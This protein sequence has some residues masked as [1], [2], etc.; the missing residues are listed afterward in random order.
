MTERAARSRGCNRAGRH[1]CRQRIT[2]SKSAAS[3]TGCAV[4]I[5]A[6][7]TCTCARGRIAAIV[8]RDMRPAAR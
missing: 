3:S 6:T 5:T 2:S 4:R 8:G 7:S 1:P